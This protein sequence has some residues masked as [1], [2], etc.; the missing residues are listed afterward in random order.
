MLFP[1]SVFIDII[2]SEFAFIK[3]YIP[4]SLPAVDIPI[5]AIFVVIASKLFL[6][7]KYKPDSLPDVDIP[8]FAIAISID[9]RIDGDISKPDV[10]ITISFDNFNR[11]SFV[12]IALSKLS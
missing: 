10:P 11:S 9:D 8:I 7:N 6:I 4:V 12:P 1:I 2:S 5:L 3:P